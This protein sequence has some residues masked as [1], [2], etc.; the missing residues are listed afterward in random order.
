MNFFKQFWKKYSTRYTRYAALDYSQYFEGQ[1]VN[2]LRLEK[3]YLGKLALPGGY[4]VACDPLLGL[5]NVQPFTRRVPP[6]QYPV[7]M[8]VAVSSVATKSALVKMSFTDEQPRQWELALLP[9]QVVSQ[10]HVE[11][12]YY[13]FT[14]NAGLG[15][16]CDAGI[17]R[18]F[19]R[20]LGR[21]F[22]ENPDRDAYVTLF[23]AAF[24]K[25]GGL[26]ANVYLPSS[27]QMN[28]VLF[29]TG[30]GDGI[31]PAYW[32]LGESGNVCSLVIDFLI[33]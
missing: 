10:E 32:G 5:H 15:C 21:F 6:G 19:N 18:Y 11:D 23:A 16:L 29:H 17:Q 28:M 2:G 13:G 8:F 12:A 31:Y 22:R 24:E 25:N 3:R 9:G 4:V 1:T 7:S 14:A 33:L 30:Y 20:Y 27:P 26:A